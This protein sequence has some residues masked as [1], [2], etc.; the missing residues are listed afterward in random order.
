MPEG[1]CDNLLCV[2]PRD[3]FY[4]TTQ[5]CNL[6]ITLLYPNASGSIFYSNT[7]TINTTTTGGMWPVR[8]WYTENGAGNL[9]TNEFNCANDTITFPEGNV[10]LVVYAQDNLGCTASDQADFQVVLFTQKHSV[11]V[12]WWPIALPILLAVFGGVQR[13]HQ[14]EETS[15][16]RR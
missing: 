13:T 15:V 11:S 1:A 9:S 12:A 4:T 2:M 16:L 7:L 14:R 3:P 6:E 8:C 10:S 5:Y